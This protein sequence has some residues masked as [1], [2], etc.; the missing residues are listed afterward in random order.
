[1]GNVAARFG[2]VPATFEGVFDPYAT[3]PVYQRPRGWRPPAPVAP[4]HYDAAL[5]AVAEMRR[6]RP[7]I[8]EASVLSKLWELRGEWEQDNGLKAKLHRADTLRLR[9]LD[10]VLD[11]Y[12]AWDSRPGDDGKP[13]GYVQVDPPSD[14]WRLIDERKIIRGRLNTRPAHAPE[15]PAYYAAR[16]AELHALGVPDDLVTALARGVGVRLRG[17][18]PTLPA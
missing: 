12:G 9:T 3:K 18:T 17:R 7:G 11:G 6:R 4:R 14:L 13:R 8:D 15:M 5:V 16:V 10:A 2:S 1:M